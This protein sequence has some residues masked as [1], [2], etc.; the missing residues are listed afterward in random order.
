MD[1]E[2]NPELFC[3]AITRL[4]LSGTL[5]GDGPLLPEL[6]EKY[7]GLE[8]LGWCG[9]DE[10][11]VQ[12]RRCKALVM[13]S[14]WLEASPLVCLESMFAAGVPSIVPDTCGAT[15]YIENGK[16]GV[17]FDNGSVESLCDA[18]RITEDMSSYSQICRNIEAELP[19]LKL[20]RSYERYADRITK[21]YEDLF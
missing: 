6:T 4:G 1:P 13:T 5:C 9:K 14:S 3:K 7:P 12:S 10:L 17:W 2:K 15:D 20:D 19:G 11:A 16:N 8:F 21:A 18:I